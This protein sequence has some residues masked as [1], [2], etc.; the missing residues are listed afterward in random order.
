M[1]WRRISVYYFQDL[2]AVR[3]LAYCGRMEITLP[4]SAVSQI[5]TGD[6]EGMERV[7]DDVIVGAED[8]RKGIMRECGIDL[9][10]NCAIAVAE[11]AACEFKNLEWHI[12]I[13]PEP[14]PG[15]MKI[16]REGE[17]G[18]LIASYG[19][20]PDGRLLRVP[21]KRKERKRKKKNLNLH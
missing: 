8:L 2:K 16:H 19:S 21:E 7:D 5:E 11:T 10:I 12:Y 18:S 15:D 4:G 17:L 13:N 20:G 6:R 1:N 3:D 9:S 14:Q